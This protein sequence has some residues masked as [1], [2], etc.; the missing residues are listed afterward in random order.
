MRWQEAQ[1]ENVMHRGDGQDL[2]RNVP[3]LNAQSLLLQSSQQEYAGVHI[4]AI[5]ARM[6]AKQ[7]TLQ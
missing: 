5:V 7:D 2:K 6:L 1:T 4:M 3:R